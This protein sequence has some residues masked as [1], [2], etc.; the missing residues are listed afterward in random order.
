MHQI[1]PYKLWIG[2]A[3]DGRDLQ[4]IFSKDI[5]AIVQLAVEELPIQTA[6]ELILCRFPL[7]DGS[8]NEDPLLS[9]AIDTVSDFI[10][11]KIPT[12]VCC[13][14]GMSRSP[15]IVAAAICLSEKIQLDDCLRFIS[16]KHPTDVSPGFWK[17]VRRIVKAD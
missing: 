3:G 5:R 15:A 1:A 2:N 10:S 14:A 12:L 17:E 9:L 4:E 6:R 16:E 7:L 13:G 8:G 11:R